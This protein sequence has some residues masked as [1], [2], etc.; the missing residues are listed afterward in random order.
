M[1]YEDYHDDWRDIIRP[2][3]LK[4]DQYKCRTC[5]I[6]HKSTVY[7]ASKGAY[8]ICDDF[9]K[10]WAINQGKKVFTIYLQVAH[11]NHDKSDN[12]PENLL[13]LCPRH[14]SIMDAEHKKLLRLT[15]RS[16]VRSQ[17]S[18]SSPKYIT[19]RG[20]MLREIQ[21]LIK[22]L[23]GI[24]IELHQAEQILTLTSNISTDE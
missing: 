20:E 24:K 3:I 19:P 1:N 21:K 23:T 4:R 17:K 18:K 2:A 9:M 16:K 5:G 6:P 10:E 7:S 22:Q 14:H 13:T 12:R 15:Y 8:V 11:L